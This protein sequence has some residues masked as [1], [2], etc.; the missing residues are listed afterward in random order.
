MKGG[1]ERGSGQGTADRQQGI[2]S[3]H[4]CMQ[5]CDGSGSEVLLPMGGAP[6]VCHVDSTY[7]SPSGCP[8][9]IS[10][11]LLNTGRNL[12]RRPPP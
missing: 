1:A 4:T 11:I 3:M 10:A 8:N 2:G 6:T 9:I 7:V 5:S 12:S